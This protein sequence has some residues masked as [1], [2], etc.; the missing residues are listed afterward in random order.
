MA[1]IR[2]ASAIG[3][4]GE[5]E[6][7]SAARQYEERCFPGTEPSQDEKSTKVKSFHPL[8]AITSITATLAALSICCTQRRAKEKRTVLLKTL[9]KVGRPGLRAA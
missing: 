6:P 8:S 9:G 1:V 3:A 5:I 2:A 4:V 7:S